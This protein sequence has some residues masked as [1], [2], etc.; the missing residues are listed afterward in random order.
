MHDM[1]FKLWKVSLLLLYALT[2]W[3]NAES[4]NSRPAATPK[5]RFTRNV[6]AKIKS[7]TR[8]DAACGDAN[9]CGYA[10]EVLPGGWYCTNCQSGDIETW[11]VQG[12]SPN[13]ATFTIVPPT[14]NGMQV[15]SITLTVDSNTAPGIYEFQVGSCNVENSCGSANATLIVLPP[16]IVFNNDVINGTTQNV[17]AG[18]QIQLSINPPPQAGHWT[19][20]GSPVGGYMV[21]STCPT[22]LLESGP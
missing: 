1:P 13:V 10:G 11:Y 14:T 17:I 8:S 16:Q 4:T 12:L 6:S 20:E 22:I 7:K 2:V 9:Y 3:A 15:T 18:Q 19:T 21:S 5:P